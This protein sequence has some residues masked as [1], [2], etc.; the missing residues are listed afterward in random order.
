MSSAFQNMKRTT[1]RVLCTLG[2]HRQE[3]NI[4]KHDHVETNPAGRQVLHSKTTPRTPLPL[5]LHPVPDL[6]PSTCTVL[7]PQPYPP[8]HHNPPSLT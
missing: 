8:P 7:M 6:T 3:I 4:S 5:P 1:A 2:K